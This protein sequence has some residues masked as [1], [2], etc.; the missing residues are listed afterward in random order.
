MSPILDI[1]MRMRELG[2]IRMGEKG[3]KGEPKKLT[4]FRLTSAS[5]A[6]L[7]AAAANPKIGGTVRQWEGAPDEGMYELYTDTDSLEIVLPPVFSLSDGTPSSP[8]SQFYE[9]WSGG[10]CQ[11]RCDGV[12]ELLSEKPCLCAA[13]GQTGRERACKITTR[14]QV[15]IP[16][17]P[18]VGVWRL[19]SHGFYAAVETPGTLEILRRAAEGMEF[20]PATLRIEQRSRKAGG[21][22]RRYIVPIVELR[23]SVLDLAAGNVEGIA[24]NAPTRPPA[25]PALPAA[26]APPVATED[27]VAAFPPVPD[28][29]TLVEPDADAPLASETVAVRPDPA[30]S[31]DSGSVGASGS[32][33]ADRSVLTKPM[34]TKLNVLVGKLRGRGHITTEQLYKAMDPDN[35]D[36]WPRDD[37]GEL[38][39]SDL[40]D[41]LTRDEGHAL[42]DRLEA[43]LTEVEASEFRVPAS[44][45][46]EIGGAA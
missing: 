30:V 40:R 31:P 19:E 17:L 14:I 2:R 21:Q 24:L 44:V 23:Q 45:Q 46:A 34:A 13:A 3:A 35:P 33:S 36:E 9:T 18:D 26:A 22:T 41:T 28:L 8:V 27:P 42:I 5:R 1:Q 7:E 37:D 15:M 25:R 20:V 43:K 11:R 16:T 4:K 29:P 38:H 12:T 32:P 6:I 39:W 10:G